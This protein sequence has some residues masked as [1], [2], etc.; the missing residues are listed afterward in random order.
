MRRHSQGP[1]RPY[2]RGHFYHNVANNKKDW[3]IIFE[4]VIKPVEAATHWQVKIGGPK[5]RSDWHDGLKPRRIKS[6]VNKG[7]AVRLG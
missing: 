6:T 4:D 5:H 7:S 3:F 2:L 1:P